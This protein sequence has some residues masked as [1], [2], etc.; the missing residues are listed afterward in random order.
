MLKRLAEYK[1]NVGVYCILASIYFLALPLTITTDSAGNS[2]LKIITL[3]IALVFLVSLFFYK[4]KLEFNSVHCFLAIYL[5]SIVSTL[6]ADRS[7]DSLLYVRGYIET[8]ALLYCITLRKY[9]DKE[10]R[11]FELVQL[12]LLCILIFLGLSGDNDDYAGAYGERTTISIFG[13]ISD[14]NYFTGFFIFPTAVALKYIAENK[15][16]WFC[17]ALVL[18]GSYVV[19]L[20]GS[21]GGLLA[22][23]VTVLA[24]A[25]IY[26]KDIRRKLAAAV[27]IIAAGMIF[28]LT[29]LPLLP[30]SVSERFSVQ[31]VIESRGTYR[32][33]IWASM[34]NEVKNST[35]ELFSGRGISAQHRMIVNG[36][37]QS[38][39][40]HN[41][42][43]QTL[44]NEGLFGFIAFMAVSAAA[45]IRNLKRRSHISAGIIGLLALSMT[46]SINPSIKSYWNLL[47]YSAFSFEIA[48][49]AE[50]SG[51]KNEA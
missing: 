25:F 8:F 24:F 51:N 21:R 14:P 38:V 10:I 47:I 12:L 33:D 5:L 9:T 1:T 44:Y 13:G 19:L 37:M 39:V 23:I 22:L 17:T 27:I 48:N 31:D 42:F 46:L 11:I 34:L 26:T 15:F 36:K 16:R 2:F 28:W 41:H 43:I 29:V 40:A 50:R 3:P 6:F 35:W 4:E 20:S 45:V 32:G 30:E 7:Y 49:T 18:L